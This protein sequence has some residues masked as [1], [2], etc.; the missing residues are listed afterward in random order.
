MDRNKLAQRLRYIARIIL[1]IILAFWF[2]F[3]LL[4]GAEE[5]GGGLK[6]II[7][8]S[9]NAIPWLLL[10]L[11]VRIAWKKELIGGSLISLMG[12]L[13][14]TFFKTYNHIEVFLLISLPLIVLGGFLVASY[15][16]DKNKQDEQPFL[17]E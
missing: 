8:N 2:I 7:T 11:L 14:I 17:K 13:T 16:L 6:G 12:V 3:A 5:Y 15:Y 1:L 4:S 10:F 9:P